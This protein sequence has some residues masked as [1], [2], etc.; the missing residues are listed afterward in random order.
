[1]DHLHK[2]HAGL[3][4]QSRPS[5]LQTIGKV[6]NSATSSSSHF[7]SKLKMKTPFKKTLNLTHFVRIPIVTR[8]SLPQILTS[9][10]RVKEDTVSANIPKGAF[11]HPANLHLPLGELSLPTPSHVEAAS[12]LL[13]SAIARQ[14]DRPFTVRVVGIGHSLTSHE[15][16][17]LSRVLRLYSR[18]EDPTTSL[19]R[20]C[21]NIRSTLLDKGLMKLD[22]C[23]RSTIPFQVK[24]IDT[25]RLTRGP[26]MGEQ[27]KWLLRPRFDATDRKYKDFVLMK[28]VHL[29]EIH[30][31]AI[32]LKEVL[33][34]NVVV[35][36]YRNIATLSLPGFD[37]DS[38]EPLETEL[39][40]IVPVITPQ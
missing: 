29:Q 24:L 1:M 2:R 15:P 27:Q 13:R 6:I 10:N 40:E 23:Q 32:G 33:Y 36:G 25:K 20:L 3:S 5:D 35:P 4:W 26:I 7:Q 11:K 8:A 19:Q 31:S 18:I 9:Y 12:K 16:R 34:E 21:H 14:E 28:D 17:S 37:A 22:P 39:D 38:A 30:I